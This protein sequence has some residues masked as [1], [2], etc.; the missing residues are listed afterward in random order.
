MSDN[1]RGALLMM[2]SMAA[3][4]LNDTAM[5]AL[6]GDAPLFQLVFMRGVLTTVLIG[7]IAWRMGALSLRLPRR[8]LVYIGLRMVAEIASA[9]FFLTALFNMPL[10]NLTAIMQS[11]PLSVTLA[12]WLFLG[13]PVGWRRMS[14]IL[15]G[16]VGVMIIVR[17]GPE[18]FNLFSIYALIAVGFVTM[19]DIVTRQLSREV[20]SM[21]VTLMTSGSVMVFFGVANVGTEWVP[22]DSKAW[23]VMLAAALMVTAGYLLS[24]MV[25]RVGEI[26][27]VAPF[28]YT[29]LIWA[30]SLGWLVFGEWPRPLTLV[31]AAI[32][33]GSGLFMLYRERQIKRSGQG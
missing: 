17:P 5:K 32:V 2:A 23:V 13:M 22:L 12:A 9:Y 20:P 33:V 8:D 7:V 1:L 14:A 3:F 31:G 30:L 25:M 10:A 19:R 29:G 27:F 16:L 26:S 18:G 4:T 6:A 15:I 28:R 11:M 24:V 21:M